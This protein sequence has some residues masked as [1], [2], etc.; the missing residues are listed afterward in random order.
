LVTVAGDETR[1]SRRHSSPAPTPRRHGQIRAAET[2]IGAPKDRRLKVI[3][4]RRAPPDSRGTIAICGRCYRPRPEPRGQSAQSSL[5]FTA[6]RL[7]RRSAG[8]TFKPLICVEVPYTPRTSAYSDAF[9]KRSRLIVRSLAGIDEDVRTETRESKI[10]VGALGP[11]LSSL[12][13]LGH[14]DRVCSWPYQNSGL[15]KQWK[16][17]LINLNLPNRT[18]LIRAI[19]VHFATSP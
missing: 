19:G 12:W 13:M 3:T 5:V 11:N 17:D 18:S 9:A 10:F 8:D 15:C 14:T 1:S 2:S 4:R 16:L 6:R 7:R